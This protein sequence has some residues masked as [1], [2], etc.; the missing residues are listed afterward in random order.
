MLNK[1]SCFAVLH[2]NQQ[3]QDHKGKSKKRIED[4]IGREHV[5]YNIHAYTQVRSYIYLYIWVSLVCI[6]SIIQYG[7]Q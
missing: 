4:A 2:H 1:L 7:V 6:L 3:H 5:T